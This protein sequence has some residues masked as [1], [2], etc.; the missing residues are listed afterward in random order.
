LQCVGKGARRYA[1]GSLLLPLIDKGVVEV[2]D[3]VLAGFRSSS[4]L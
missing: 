3:F 1:E 2:H 4:E